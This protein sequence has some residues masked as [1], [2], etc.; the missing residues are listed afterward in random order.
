MGAAL[1]AACGTGWNAA[2]PEELGYEVIGVDATEA[3]LEVARNKVSRATFRLGNLE[4]LPVADA[5]VDV[6]TCSLAL[7]HVAEITPAIAEMARVRGP[8]VGSCSPTS[9]LSQC[10]SVVPPSF[11]RARRA[12]SF[13]SS[14]TSSTLYGSTSRC[15]WALVPSWPSVEKRRSPRPRSSPTRR[16]QSFPTPFGRPLRA[17][18][19]S[20]HG[21]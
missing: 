15:R 21:G 3:M 7:T 11:L 10:C 4:S 20:L 5:S 16:T 12:C 14:R 1:D 17:C 6:I 18:P 9:T 19:S 8:G 13:R 2:H